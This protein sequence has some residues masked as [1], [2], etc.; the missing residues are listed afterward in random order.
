M[1]AL[2]LLRANGVP[3][4]AGPVRTPIHLRHSHPRESVLHYLPR[5]EEVQV[6]KTE[7]RCSNAEVMLEYST[8]WL[9]VPRAHTE[10][11]ARSYCRTHL[12]PL[13]EEYGQ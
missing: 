4:C 3:V 7:T 5:D 2:S 12:P 9:A 13:S 1:E 6:W 10:Q 8:R 11:I